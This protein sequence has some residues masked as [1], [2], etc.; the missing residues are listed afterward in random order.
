[1]STMAGRASKP[2]SSVTRSDPS[3]VAIMIFAASLFATLGVLS[4]TAYDQGLTPFA[5][6][7]WRAGIGG[8]GLWV[9]VLVVRGRRS[10]LWPA[11]M[12]GAT[13]KAMS[14][15]ILTGAALN[16][17][18]F[19]AFDHTTVALALL[20]FYTYPAM[21][22]AASV[23]LGRERLDTPRALALVLALA[24]MGA[25]VLGG[26]GAEFL[27]R[28]EPIGI[29]AALGAAACQAAFVLVSRGYAEV[30]ND[31][32]MASILGAPGIVAV[33]VTIVTGGPSLLLE[34]LANGQLLALLI[35]VGIFTAAVP[36]YLFLI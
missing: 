5:F 3:G 34:P 35:G 36:A 8:I 21:V 1:M 22:A 28:A 4:R 2:A 10:V 17:R 27:I 25:V 18:M 11:Q 15:A 23:A 33:L 20:A 6:V 32:A 9:A 12:S 19:Y 16:L 13:R 26:L 14:L 24:G 29:A 30:P 7:A 31:Q